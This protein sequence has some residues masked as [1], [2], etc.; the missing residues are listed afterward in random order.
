MSEKVI[1]MDSDCDNRYDVDEYD[2]DDPGFDLGHYAAF[3]GVFKT[4]GLEL[5]KD[6]V[7]LIASRTA[8]KW[9]LAT[10]WQHHCLDRLQDAWD[11]EPKQWTLQFPEAVRGRQPGSGYDGMF[12]VD[13][14]Y[15]EDNTVWEGEC[16][17]NMIDDVWHRGKCIK[18]KQ[19]TRSIAV[20]FVTHIAAVE[21]DKTREYGTMLPHGMKYIQ[22]DLQPKRVEKPPRGGSNRRG[23]G[24]RGGGGR[25]GGG[26]GG[27]GRGG[28]RGGR[29]EKGGSEDKK[30]TLDEYEEEKRKKREQEE[31]KKRE[32][33]EKQK[34]MTPEEIEKAQQD[35]NRE[36]QR[37][38]RDEAREAEARKEAEKKRQREAEKKAAAVRDMNLRK[39]KRPDQ[40]L[41]Y[42]ELDV[43]SFFFSSCN[44]SPA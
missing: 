17:F 36:E 40:K 44:L 12:K 6:R 15:H 38:L 23:G 9:L 13:Q 5:K 10:A 22:P 18:G 21:R 8:G 7:Y 35:H 25:G 20:S 26:R 1:S 16:A 29:H 34:D 2:G 19:M 24:R 14:A 33:E 41:G 27:G 4:E 11:A 32:Q 39:T 28:G 30:L 43:S 42:M 37:R 3:D 31:R